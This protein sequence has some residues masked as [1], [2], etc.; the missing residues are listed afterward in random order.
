M[1]KIII[2]PYSKRLRKFSVNDPDK[3]NP[4]NYP[5]WK[6]VVLLLK[7]KG[8]YIIQIG[9][10]GEDLIGADEVKFNLNIKDL[11]SLLSECSTWIC[12]DNFFNHFATYYKKRGVVI[13]SRSDPL[14]FGYLQNINLLKDR[15]YL[16]KNQ[17]ELWEQD[18]F[19]KDAFVSP[20]EVAR[21]V[22]KCL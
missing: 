20:E 5:Y 18:E 8:F 17:F 16:R 22:E 21:S 13:F 15:K 3:T 19:N 6:E 11:I 10:P 14:I 9:V 12:V 1:K 7:N 2:S 4:K